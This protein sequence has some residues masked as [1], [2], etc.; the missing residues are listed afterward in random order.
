MAYMS[1][2]SGRQEVYVRP[3]PGP[4]DK[5]LVSTAGGGWPRWRRDGRE[6]FYLA[7]DGNL[8]AVSVNGAGSS[9]VVG[10]GRPL[11]NVRMRP[12][13]R[14]DAYSYDVTADAQ[15]F[16]INTFVEEASP[17]AITLVVNWPR[18]VH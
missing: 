14:L 15:R 18:T 13:V 12:M 6:L 7:R 8:M 9:F 3:F 2:E 16:L 17:P 10:E 11:F 5:W 4:G 1:N